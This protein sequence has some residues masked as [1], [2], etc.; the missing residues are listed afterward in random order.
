M[1]QRSPFDFDVSVSAAKRARARGRGRGMSGAVE[2]STRQCDW[3]GCTACG[4]YRAPVSPER[5][6]EYHWFC[7]EH[8][9]QYNRSWNYFAEFSDEEF[10]AWTRDANAW[11]RPTWD[12]R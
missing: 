11:E 5:L 12:F 10:D 6:N 8:V 3:P 7:L 9:R 1:T 4:Q 2:H